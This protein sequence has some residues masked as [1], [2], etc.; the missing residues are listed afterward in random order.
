MDRNG[1]H[2]LDLVSSR[3]TEPWVEDLLSPA[4]TSRA[5]G[6]IIL[7]RLDMTINFSPIHKIGKTEQLCGLDPEPLK[8]QF[9]GLGLDDFEWDQC[10]FPGS[11]A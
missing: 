1:S 8:L 5:D 11:R 2:K 6:L 7:F 10:S 9:V 4:R 3:G